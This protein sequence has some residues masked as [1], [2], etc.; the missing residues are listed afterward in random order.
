[1]CKIMNICKF[2]SRTLLFAVVLSLTTFVSCEE[3]GGETWKR[4]DDMSPYIPDSSVV[5]RGS[6]SIS[7]S[8]ASF[9]LEPRVFA[10]FDYWQ[11]KIKS[12][13]YYIDGNLIKTETK[14]PYSLIYTEPGLA[15]GRHQLVAN[16]KIEDLVNHREI[17][18]S[19]VN[20]FEIKPG[21]QPDSFEGLMY[22]AGWTK[23]GNNAYINIDNVGIWSSL[24]DSGWSLTSVSFCFDNELI[25]TVYEEPFGITYTAKDLSKGKHY[26]VIKGKVVNVSNSQELELVSEI[27]IDMP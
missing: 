9:N 1:M 18:I 25:D 26:L 7:G 15:E 8:V 27:E 12:I 10:N 23:S 2:I 17:V 3:I 4:P 6:W 5:F 21:S 14:E 13:D 11:L 19:P 24:V 22:T 20:E 16:V